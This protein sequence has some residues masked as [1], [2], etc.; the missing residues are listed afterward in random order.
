MIA[1]GIRRRPGRLRM[2]LH[3]LAGA[4]GWI[5]LIILAVWRLP[6]TPPWQL[7]LPVGLTILV[8]AA[9][10]M[11]AAL[12]WARMADRRRR[13]TPGPMKAPPRFREKPREPDRVR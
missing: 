6:E 11:L 7:P 2:W 10:L 12:V 5:A 4:V 9:L 3:R 13:P 1:T 8:L